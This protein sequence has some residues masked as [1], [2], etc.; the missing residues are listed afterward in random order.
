MKRVTLVLVTAA[1]LPMFLPIMVHA[2][3]FF[4]AGET[5]FYNAPKA[6]IRT[7][8]SL[9]DQDF[10]HNPA[11]LD[12]KSDLEFIMDSY[13][14]GSTSDVSVDFNFGSPLGLL[15]Y[16]FMD[17]EY[18]IDN[19]G[20]DIGFMK[21]LNDRSSLG[22][23]FSYS[24]EEFDGDGSFAQ[25]FDF[26]P[27]GGF[28]YL[29]G[30]LDAGMSSNTFALTA[31][32]DIDLSGDLSLGAG[33][34]Y[35]YIN[36]KMEYDISGSGLLTLFSRPENVSIDK[37]MTFDY[38]R[39]S[40]VFGMSVRP[41][42]PLVINAS[43]TAG[44]YLGSVERVSN[45]FDDYPTLVIPTSTYTEKLDSNDLLVLDVAFRTDGA[46]EIIPERLS[47]PF[48]FDCT[49]GTARWSVDGAASG[50]FHPAIYYAPF[51]GPGTI[52]YGNTTEH[53]S[54]SVGGGVDYTVGG[55][56]L[57]ALIGYSHLDL[58]NSFEMDNYVV[59]SVVL[60]GGGPLR[61]LTAFSQDIEETWDVFS[62]ELGAS[63]EFSEK[64]SADVCARYD[65][66]WGQMDLETWYTSPFDFTPVGGFPGSSIEM[67]LSDREVAHTLTLS[68]YLAYSPVEYLNLS[69]QGMVGI[70]LSE[71]NY[72]LGGD[73][74]GG[75]FGSSW[76]YALGGPSSMDMHYRGWDY[77]GMFNIEYA[78]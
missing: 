29:Y 74:A 70:P 7:D 41:V 77:G 28:D 44:I 73:A 31:L 57:S 37:E 1:F 72:T 30:T 62:F 26:G 24:R 34:S 55:F 65:I 67:D 23:V 52:E 40:P 13:Y 54:V 20:A 35:A 50:Y 11:L 49:Y 51:Q 68:A 15:Y 22:L 61:G 17:A 69:F 64:L 71:I 2:Q 3:D 78:F 76:R 53:W 21:R 59:S 42:D 33:I 9:W 38:H 19:T 16:G 43:L 5:G 46:Y 32:Y 66:G 14:T 10:K 48:F 75:V 18:R 12:P 56:D 36:N 25:F 4:S 27:L 58:K 63:R 47:L 45:L 60:A 8:A 6:L 39:I